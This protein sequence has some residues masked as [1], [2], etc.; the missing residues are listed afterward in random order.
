M[1]GKVPTK[2]QYRPQ[3]PKKVSTSLAPA[4]CLN[5]DIINGRFSSEAQKL[6]KEVSYFNYNHNFP[7]VRLSMFFTWFHF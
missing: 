7:Q 4:A 1:I 6:Y 2:E 5:K 3:G